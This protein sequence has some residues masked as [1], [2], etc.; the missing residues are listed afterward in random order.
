[1]NIIKR[2]FPESEEYNYDVLE[3]FIDKELTPERRLKFINKILPYVEQLS[4]NYLDSNFNNVRLNTVVKMTRLQVAG[5]VASSFLCAIPNEEGPYGYK[6]F[7]R[8]FHRPKRVSV[9]SFPSFNDYMIYMNTNMQNEPDPDE[10]FNLS[11]E[12]L[13]FMLGYFGKV[14]EHKYNSFFNQNLMTFARTTA[15]NYTIS[16]DTILLTPV[17]FHFGS[18]E[19]I[20]GHFRVNFANKHTGGKVLSTG[21]CQEEIKFLTNPELFAC[22]IMSDP[23][24]DSEVITISGAIRYSNYSGYGYD[25]RYAGN[26]KKLIHDRILELDAVQYTPK[27]RSIQY[28]KEHMNR[29][30]HK[31][32]IGFAACNSETIITGN[33]GCGAFHGDPVLKFLIQLYAASINHKKLIFC[34][35]N[36]SMLKK[37]SEIYQHMTE[38]NSDDLLEHLYSFET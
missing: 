14:H 35:Y 16:T 15:T 17:E 23:L 8:I 19:D 29:E 32:S 11:I 20:N 24:T 27:D 22:L 37:L 36:Q 1:M 9:S 2:F 26:T 13:K 6:N 10:I 33:W 25:L 30:I 31:A 4:N 7:H 21:C 3:Y 5:M 34:G 12:K 18:M 38:Y 28:S